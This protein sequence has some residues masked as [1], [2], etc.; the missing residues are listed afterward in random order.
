MSLRDV[1]RVLEVMS[2]FYRQTQGQTDL[3][4]RLEKN[5]T[6]AEEKDEEEGLAEDLEMEDQI[7][8]PYQVGTPEQ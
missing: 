4:N 5:D 6:D 3:F 1:E 7:L 2:W 8:Q